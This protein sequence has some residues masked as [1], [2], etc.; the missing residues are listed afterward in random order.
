M[1]KFLVW[2][3]CLL[4]AGVVSSI[5]LGASSS[6]PGS[7]PDNPVRE[8]GRVAG[9]M[10]KVIIEIKWASDGKVE[11]VRTD[12][13]RP[14]LQLINETA[15]ARAAAEGRQISFPATRTTASRNSSTARKAEQSGW[16]ACAR[17]HNI[18]KNGGTAYAAVAVSCTPNVTE[19]NG[20]LWFYRGSGWTNI[21][22]DDGISYAYWGYWQADGTC[23][24][25]TWQYNAI[26][27]YAVET[28]DMGGWWWGNFYHGPVWMSC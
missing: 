17:S 20:T 3:A 1:K 12:A 16:T 26:F 15:A 19:I 6:E 24:Q 8:D 10:S 25:S 13:D 7:S 4:A 22:F 27:S 23:A 9:V 11:S 2:L 18:W 21:G 14:S 5:S 28:N